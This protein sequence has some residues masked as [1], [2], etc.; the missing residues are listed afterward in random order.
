M[1]GHFLSAFIGVCISK[2]FNVGFSYDSNNLQWLAASL[3]TAIS[4]VVMQATKTTHPPAG[5][6]ALLPCVESAVRGLGWYYLPVILLSSV[7]VLVTALLFN[8]TQRQ[9]PKFWISPST[10]SDPTLPPPSTAYRES[11]DLK[12]WL[13]RRSSSAPPQLPDEFDDDEKYRSDSL[14]SDSSCG[15]G[16]DKSGNTQVILY[17]PGKTRWTRN[18]DKTLMRGIK[19]GKSIDEIAQE[20]PGRTPAAVYQRSYMVPDLTEKQR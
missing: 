11:P 6:T 19:E 2:I 9:Y 15:S 10:P 3:A 8:N 20:F 4:L 13:K 5:A 16:S 1:G 18:E 12:P 14:D 17:M 7:V